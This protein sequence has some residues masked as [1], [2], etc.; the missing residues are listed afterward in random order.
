M[1]ETDISYP[2]MLVIGFMLLI[3]GGELAKGL[4]KYNSYRPHKNLDG[5]TPMACIKNAHAEAASQSQSA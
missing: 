2:L 1:L 4:D 5:L 3:G